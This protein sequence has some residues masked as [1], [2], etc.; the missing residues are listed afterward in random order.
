MI[1]VD[2]SVWIDHLHRTEDALV[3][4]LSADAV[5]SHPLVLQELALGSIRR[6]H[7]VLD[8]LS[9]LYRFPAVAHDEVLHLIDSHRLWGRGVGVV[10]AHLMA[11]VLLTP[12]G[13][14]WTRDKRLRSACSAAGVNV[15]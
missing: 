11:A 1:L 8:L 5:G 15:L 12:G 10:D 7:V 6:R 4:L 14:L 13:R 3:E 9:N 2:T